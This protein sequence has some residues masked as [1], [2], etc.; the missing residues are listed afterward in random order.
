MLGARTMAEVPQLQTA[1]LRANGFTLAELK[2]AGYTERTLTAAGFASDEV[3]GAVS[4]ARGAHRSHVRPQDA[5]DRRCAEARARQGQR[6]PMTNKSIKQAVSEFRRESETFNSPRALERWGRMAD[7]DVSA[8]T[9]MS[10]LFRD[11]K[12]FSEDIGDWDVSNVTN[13]DW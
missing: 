9:D 3:H 6:P 12:Q 11:A 7:W 2:A 10:E 8:V 1:E 13:M 4:V 5:A